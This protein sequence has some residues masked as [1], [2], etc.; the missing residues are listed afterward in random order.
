MA[1]HRSTG[2]APWWRLQFEDLRNYDLSIVRCRAVER[3]PLLRRLRCFVVF[4]GAGG[5]PPD[6]SRAS[7]PEA[8]ADPSACSLCGAGPGAIGADGF[9]ARCGHERVDTSRHH[10]EIAISPQLAGV[11]DIGL[12]H[13]RNEDALAIA[14]GPGGEAIVVCDGV[15]R[16]QNPDMASAVAA[17]AA[18]DALR[19]T[20]ATPSSNHTHDLV[21]AALLAAQTAIRT[22]PRRSHRGGRSAGVDDRRRPLP[23]SAG[24]LGM[25]RR[26][27]RVPRL[28]PTT[29]S[30]APSITPG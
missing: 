11:S 25:D 21:T 5:G 3:S 26:Q 16:S 23:R 20:L 12:R 2:Q 1:K 30:N 9:C 18:L 27:P 29:R 14:G 17:E 7:R 10:V 19:G 4:A 6:A 24:E 28:P 22:I 8:A 15:S 13:F